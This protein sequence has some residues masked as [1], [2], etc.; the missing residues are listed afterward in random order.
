MGSNR[1][2]VVGCA[3]AEGSMK[4]LA[5]LRTLCLAFLFGVT[6]TLGQ[7]LLLC[8]KAALAR[9]LGDG[10]GDDQSVVQPMVSRS[11][12]ANTAK[13]EPDTFVT[14]R[15]RAGATAMRTAGPTSS[16]SN[17]QTSAAAWVETEENNYPVSTAP[18]EKGMD[19]LLGLISARE[20]NSPSPNLVNDGREFAKQFEDSDEQF[21]L[22]Q[23]VTADLTPE[24]ARAQMLENNLDELRSMLEDPALHVAV[25]GRE[26][27]SRMLCGVA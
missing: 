27:I 15:R 3:E 9:P 25:N 20:Y 18:S 14:E 24:Q 12:V 2:D 1:V 26:Q 6:V 16:K 13:H 5:S 21:P 17:A 4:A 10:M 7:Q 19:S 8:S 11:T 23:Q 22:E